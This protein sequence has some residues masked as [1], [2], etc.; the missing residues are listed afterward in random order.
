MSKINP[1]YLSICTS[2]KYLFGAFK[3]QFFQSLICL[4]YQKGHA[5]QIF[6]SENIVK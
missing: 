3:V 5:A 6:K 2:L 4:P 1:V